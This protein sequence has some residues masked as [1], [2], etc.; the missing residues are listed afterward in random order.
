MRAA[1]SRRRHG[2]HGG[3]RG[4]RA[5]W[6]G[7]RGAS[8]PRPARH[9]PLP[10]ASAP[11]PAAQ[12]LAPKLFRR[13]RAACRT[14]ATRSPGWKRKRAEHTL[15]IAIVAA[16]VAPAGGLRLTMILVFSEPTYSSV[17]ATPRL[18]PAASGALL[19]LS[20]GSRRRGA[21]ASSASALGTPPTPA[22]ADE[23]DPDQREHESRRSS[24]AARSSSST[25]PPP[26]R[27][28][29]GGGGDGGSDTSGGGGGGLAVRT[30]PQRPQLRWQRSRMKSPAVVLPHPLALWRAHQPLPCA[31]S[32]RR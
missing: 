12:R 20:A 31:S 30:M 14:S 7:R 4:R 17:I 5:R 2:I 18:A 21:R 15:L 25:P 3:A 22:D 11:R 23:A 26:A 27:S 32:R 29:D 8:R 24:V 16:L 28:T 6:C 9:C 10:R 13:R 19:G 1:T